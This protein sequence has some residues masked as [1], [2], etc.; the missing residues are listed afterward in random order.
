MGEVLEDTFVATLAHELREPFS[1]MFAAVE[2]VRVAPESEA[3]RRAADI[4]RQ[5]LE[6]MTR[7][8]DDLVDAKRLA[9]GKVS[10]HRSRVDLRDVM[11]DARKSIASAV[12]DSGQELVFTE[13]RA[14][15][16]ID[17]DRPRLLQALLNLLRNAVKFTP[18]G[19][20]ITMAVERASS[21]VT[22]RVADT[23]R[24]IETDALPHIFELFCPIRP[25]EGA[26]LGIGLSIVCD[27]VLLHGGSVEARSEGAW[28]GSEFIVRLPAAEATAHADR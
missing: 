21:T 5:R 12:A 28:K 19:G 27:I 11:R 8:V 9:C 10:L 26:G 1:A 4:M 17:A 2:V 24:G 22:V 20:R 23:G 18:A 16:W 25:Q 15:I 3:A 6:E 14:P 7:L 13:E